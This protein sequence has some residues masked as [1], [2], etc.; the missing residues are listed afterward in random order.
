MKDIAIPKEE[1]FI[2]DFIDSISNIYKSSNTTI[3]DISDAIES[4]I[5]GFKSNYETLNDLAFYMFEE[6]IDEEITHKYFGFINDRLKSDYYL[7][8]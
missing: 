4:C 2:D 7:T 1:E 6:F 3:T 5:T 8:E